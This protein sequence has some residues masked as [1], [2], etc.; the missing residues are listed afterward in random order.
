MGIKKQEFYEGAALHMLARKGQIASIRYDWPFFQFNGVISVLLKYNTKSR[1]PWAFTITP[2][3]QTLLRSRATHSRAALALVCG[4]DGVVALSYDSFLSVASLRDRAIHIS[5]YRDH[6]EHYE[7]N[8]PDGR[9][10]RKISP[11]N[12]PKILEGQ[13]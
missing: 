8:G 10:H 4:A 12:W 9:L 3:E 5:C 13:E 1:S 2:E 11:S 6:G 7:V